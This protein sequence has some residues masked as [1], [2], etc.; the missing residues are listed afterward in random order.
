VSRIRTL[1]EK[2]DHLGHSCALIAE[3]RRKVGC[4]AVSIAL[5]NQEKLNRVC[6][7]KHIDDVEDTVFQEDVHRVE[8]DLQAQLELL[9]DC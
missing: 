5:D 3:R 6:H 1:S 9:G 4:L 2:I 7:M 8:R